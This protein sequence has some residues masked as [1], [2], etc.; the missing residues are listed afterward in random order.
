MPYDLTAIESYCHSE[1]LRLERP[2]SEEVRV[3]VCQGSQLCFANT[4]R[5]TDTYVGFIDSAWHSHGDLMLMTGPDTCVELDPIGVL[6]G[7][8]S[9]ELLIATQYVGGKIKDRWIFH[10]KEEQD[11]QYMEPSESICVQKADPA[12]TDN[13]GASPLRV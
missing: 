12:G 3:H 4:E 10:R 6:A 9:G 8:K 1:R 13:S 7:L 11:F 5:G 2:S